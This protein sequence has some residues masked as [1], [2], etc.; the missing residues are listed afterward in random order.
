MLIERKKICYLGDTS[1]RIRTLY[2]R[3]AGQYSA[4]AP[5]RAGQYHYV[6]HHVNAPF[7]VIFDRWRPRYCLLAIWAPPEQ[8]VYAARC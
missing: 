8:K 5:L 4:T 7:P 3:F 2:F 1:A 6:E